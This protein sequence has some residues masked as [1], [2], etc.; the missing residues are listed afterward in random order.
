[1]AHE[2]DTHVGQRIRA[3]RILAGHSQMELGAQIGVKFQ[4][5]QKYET[6]ANRVSASKLWLVAEFLDRPIESFF[7][8]SE[9]NAFQKMVGF[10][11]KDLRL[12]RMI[13]SLSESQKS[14]VMNLVDQMVDPFRPV[15][16]EKDG[17][18]DA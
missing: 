15:S 13:L 9:V 5:V 2:I 11:D 16:R 7:P 18:G 1:M 8:S 12:F 17:D 6:G 3:E 10:S 14:A 4:Q